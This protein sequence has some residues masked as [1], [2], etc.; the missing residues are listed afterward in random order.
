M[1][2]ESPDAHAK[3]KQQMG[4]AGAGA[5]QL[6]V[7]DDMKRPE[8]QL[9]DVD[10][11]LDEYQLHNLAHEKSREA[12]AEITNRF[13]SNICP[14]NGT[15]TSIF[16]ESRDLSSHRHFMVT[17]S[18]KQRSSL[19]N[20]LQQSHSLRAQHSS[21]QERQELFNHCVMS[22]PRIQVDQQVFSE[23]PTL[24]MSRLTS[25]DLVRQNINMQSDF[26]KDIESY[27]KD[28]EAR[29][30]FDTADCL[31]RHEIKGPVRARMI[32]WMI[33]VLTNFNC[34]EQTFFIAVQ[35]MDRYFKHAGQ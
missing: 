4:W 34:D 14:S 19:H 25:S 12:L 17:G 8:D 27:L 1:A 26:A 20:S 32:D 31:N 18:G 22:T 5:D 16:R 29:P 3:A 21:S 24:K 6:D 10:E 7:D 30:Q 35:I 11:D 28:R 23:H 9:L 13:N 15:N 2:D 33:E